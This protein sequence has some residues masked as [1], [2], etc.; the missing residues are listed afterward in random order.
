MRSKGKAKLLVSIVL[1]IVLLGGGS[2][3]AAL[4]ASLKEEPPRRENAKPPNVVK[5]ITL[6]PQNITERFIGYGT[7]EP[8]RKSRIAAEVTARVVA[9]LRDCREGA[10]VDDDMPL[11]QFDD[12][13][14]QR[15]L[16]RAEALADADQAGIDELK[17]ESEKL[18]ELVET[19]RYEKEVAEAEWERV[20]DLFNRRL[21]AKKEFD[22]ANLARQ[23][24]LRVLQGYERE[25][26]KIAPRSV[27]LGASRAAR[28]AEVETARLNIER[29]TIST[30]YA[31]QISDRHVEVGD[32]VGPGTLVLSLV[33]ASRVEIAA[34]LPAAVYN[35]VAPG[36]SCTIT[37]ESLVETT[38]S[39]TVAR[40]APQVDE[41]RRTFSAYIVVDNTRQ[42]TPCVPGMFV[43]VDVE[44]P[45]HED[46]FLVP[47]GALLGNTVFVMDE[48]RSRRR[49]IEPGRY[50]GDSVIIDGGIRS[51]D[52]VI[53]PP[54]A[55]L[56]DGTEVSL[57][58][59]P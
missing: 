57:P 9:F 58:N 31:G 48:G 51:G 34:Q 32:W 25:L 37:S 4:L 42:T 33:D 45:T 6:A 24:A 53:L 8:I 50:V 36:A 44:G 19:A 54:L 27:Q 39:G 7:V 43:T 14:Y 41:E 46:V 16:Q 12:R 23:Q 55:A 2:V 28:L 11:I 20:S 52:Q 47:R 13:E 59:Q 1:V 30:P 5:T 3:I 38:W 15:A 35:R 49:E 26:S 18:G 22:F 40:I 10:F 56:N 21:A 29:C 17:T